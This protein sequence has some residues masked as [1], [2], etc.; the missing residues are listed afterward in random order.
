MQIQRTRN[1]LAAIA[2]LFAVSTFAAPT[3]FDLAAQR[4]KVERFADE[5]AAELS[6]L[7]PAAAPGDQ[8][9]FESCRQGL[10]NDSFLKRNLLPIAL[11]GRVNRD[12]QKMIKDTTLTQF[13]GDV[14]TGMYVPLFMFNGKYT[15]SYDEREKMFLVGMDVGFRNRLSPGEFP[16]PFWH[17][18]SKWS[19]YQGAN[20]VRFWVDPKQMKI[21]VA[22]FTDRGAAGSM[23]G[24]KPVPHDFG[25]KWMWTD[26]QGQEQPQ[27]T[28]FDGLFSRDNPNL[29]KLDSSYRTLALKLREGQ[30]M[31]CH[32]P[33]NPNEMKRI[34]LLQTPAHAAGEIR[35]LM[36]AVREDRMPRDETGIEEPLDAKTKKALLEN[37]G[38]FEQAY[39]SAKEWERGN[40]AAA[41]RRTTASAGASR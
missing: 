19:T 37:A 7:C 18:A 17:D 35:R 14:L 16:Y 1:L 27:V 2:A 11:W 38:A 25:G 23:T 31:N 40:Q 24:S 30:C 28:L 10:F 20:Q 4:P 8:A 13:G 3:D 33:D 6:M 32:T 39:E 29:Q 36:K 9:A 15:V 12:P 5:L 26:A 34:V 21:K 41:S 22:Q